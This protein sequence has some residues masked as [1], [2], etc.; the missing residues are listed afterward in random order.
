M[1]ELD[2]EERGVQLCYWCGEEYDIEDMKMLDDEPH[3]PHCYEER[4]AKL[5]D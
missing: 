4:M 3:C 5:N 1:E 2:R